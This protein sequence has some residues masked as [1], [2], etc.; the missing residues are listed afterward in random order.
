MGRR[1]IPF[2]DSPDSGPDAAFSFAMSSGVLSGP[3]LEP[4]GMSFFSAASGWTNPYPY[5]SSGSFRPFADAGSPAV[6]VIRLAI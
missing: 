5:F 2:P 4:G 6:C 1:L 3:F